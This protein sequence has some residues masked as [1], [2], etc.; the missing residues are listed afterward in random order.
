MQYIVYEII[1]T[2]NSIKIIK[3][4]IKKNPTDFWEFR[5]Q[6]EIYFLGHLL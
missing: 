4:G 2:N 3:K 1:K 6:K 5:C